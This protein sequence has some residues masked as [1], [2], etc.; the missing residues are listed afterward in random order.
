[1]RTIMATMFLQMKNSFA[2]PTFKFV[3]LLQPIFF[4]TITYMVY[5]DSGIDSYLSYV[6]FGTGLLNL[7]S[8]IVYSSAGD[9]ERERG[10]GNLEI[11]G[12][13][14]TPFTKILY[15]KILGNTILG[16]SSLLITFAWV[17]VVFGETLTIRHPI[18]FL[19]GFLL[20][21]FSFMGLAIIVGLLFTMS[22]SARGLMN[23][24]EYPVYI[25]TGMVFPI[26]LLPN[27][28]LPLSWSLSPTWVVKIFNISVKG[29]TDQ[30]E[31]LL[32]VLML[33]TLCIGYYLVGEWLFR[34]VHDKTRR[35]GTLGVY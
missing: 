21:I 9:I 25:L 34:L 33:V 18:L 10:M 23:C 24:V 30:Q 27:C 12:I 15:G 19:T 32:P 4:S 1:M 16:I 7:W 31:I 11:L 29:F 6:I 17:A 22:R 35:E 26:S 14:S 5:K 13:T 28:F 8:S 20:M 2:R 3:I